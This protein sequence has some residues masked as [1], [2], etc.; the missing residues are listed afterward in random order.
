M[1]LI[2]DNDLCL[3]YVRII[4][5]LIVI[6]VQSLCGV[7]LFATPWTAARQASLSFTASWS[8]LKLMSVD[9]VMPSKYQM[10]MPSSTYLITQIVFFL[11]IILVFQ[12]LKF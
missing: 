12:F 1:D 3:E 4:Y 9:S 10:L 6:V 2:S 7:W 11:I 5:G 8:L